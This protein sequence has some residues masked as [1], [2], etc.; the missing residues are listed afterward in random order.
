MIKYSSKMKR[1]YL[2]SV[3]LLFAYS[4]TFAYNAINKISANI[5]MRY[6]YSENPKHTDKLN[7]L[8]KS[9]SIRGLDYGTSAEI[10]SIVIKNMV[11]DTMD[12]EIIELDK[13][14]SSIELAL[15]SCTCVCDE[16]LVQINMINYKSYS[17]LTA[18]TLYS[19]TKSALL[20]KDGFKEGICKMILEK[21]KNQNFDMN[22][23]ICNNQQANKR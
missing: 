6:L 22:G 7:N 2:I 19:T 1:L 18:D 20:L 13:A 3:V 4:L 11:L 8:L 23:L 5:K 12:V 10:D 21:H 14:K 15:M 16:I 17:C 9:N